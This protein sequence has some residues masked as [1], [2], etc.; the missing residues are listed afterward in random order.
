M[1]LGQN[2]KK[3]YGNREVLNIK[4]ISVHPGEIVA[5]IGPSGSGKS[6]L[7]RALALLN[8]PDEGVIT[9]DDKNYR[10][11]HAGDDQMS[12]PWPKVTLVFQ[13]LFL[14]PH[15]TIEKNIEL[16]LKGLDRRVREARIQGLAARLR[17][18][19]FINRYPNQISVGQRQRAAIA[20]AFSLEPTY[21]L[22]DEI[23][24]ALD[25][26]HINLV[27]DN[28]RELAANGTA[29]V[30]VTHLIGFAKRAA[31]QILFMENGMIVERGKAKILVKPQSPRLKTFLSLIEAT[32]DKDSADGKAGEF[33]RSPYTANAVLS[34]LR[35]GDQPAD[36]EAVLLDRTPLVD[37][38]RERVKDTDITRLATLLESESAHVAGLAASLLKRFG[39]DPVVIALYESAW[40]RASPYL[41]SRLLWRLM[42]NRDKA[43]EMHDELFN[44]VVSEWCTFRDFNLKFFGE[45][46]EATASILA[47]L[48]SEKEGPHKKWLY[49]CSIPEVVPDPEMAHGLVQM[50][51]AM[52]FPHMKE[53]TENLLGRF[54]PTENSVGPGRA[55]GTVELPFDPGFVARAVVDFLRNGARPSEEESDVFNR[56]PQVDWLR[57][58]IRPDDVM[59]WLIPS[60]SE[61]SEYAGLCLSLLRKYDE[62]PDVQ[63]FLKARW[64]T[65]SPFLRA[66][67]LWRILDD[68][69]LPMEW[70]ETVFQF[71]LDHMGQFHAVSLRFLGTSEDVVESARERY[72]DP[73]FPTSK[74]WAYLCRVAGIAANKAEAKAFLQDALLDSHAFN[75]H[76]AQTLLQIYY[77]EKKG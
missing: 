47:R 72:E 6:T 40:K 41:K 29:I 32:V 9:I 74:K 19:N 23:T 33:L 37:E 25:V 21:L 75:K 34:S 31:S 55:E 68:P 13:Q 59:K 62:Q 7:L 57:E 1:L 58:T 51:K 71:V 30:L 60:V 11:P 16:P 36:A 35:Q 20:R 43:E 10:F 3:S 38:I 44:F 18:N 61:D 64:Q 39:Q 5:I 77:G 17:L 70:H 50:G 28:L 65:A 56:H 69:K 42:D 53:T 49:L 73:R 4:E 14:W 27:L 46:N 76:V 24:S 54:W 66:H 12:P 45:A 22:L 48:A 26:E 52:N 2:I 8:P 15:L 67:L 63:E